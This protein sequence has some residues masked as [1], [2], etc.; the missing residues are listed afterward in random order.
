MTF[1][2][3]LL[4]ELGLF[5]LVYLT[6]NEI[7][8]WKARLKGLPGPSGLPVVGNLPQVSSVLY[9]ILYCTTSPC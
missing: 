8:R 9:W 7:I 3:L 1:L 2:N 5:L 4:L 6:M